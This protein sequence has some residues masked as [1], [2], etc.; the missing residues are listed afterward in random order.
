MITQLDIRNSSLQ[1]QDTVA[2]DKR[3]RAAYIGSDKTTVL[4][5]RGSWKVALVTQSARSSE[6]PRH[7]CFCTDRIYTG[8]IYT[9]LVWT[10]NHPV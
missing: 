9:R 4:P 6:E 8:N 5:S 10:R 2:A 3:S 1:S 7:C